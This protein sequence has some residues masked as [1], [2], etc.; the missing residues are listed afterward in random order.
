MRVATVAVLLSVTLS[1]LAAP[2]SQPVKRASAGVLTAQ[3]YDEFN[4]SGG[5][6]GNALA[7]VNAKFPVSARPG[8]LLLLLLFHSP[9]ANH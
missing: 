7:E 6:A 5:V 2:I 4:V 1:S 8:R 3:S 9:T